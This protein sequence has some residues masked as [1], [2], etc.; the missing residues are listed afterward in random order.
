M[1][2]AF[3]A[4]LATAAP[5]SP[6]PSPTP[7]ASA[8]LILDRGRADR[9]PVASPVDDQAAPSGGRT[10]IEAA[11]GGTVIRRIVFA[12]GAVPARVAAAAQGFVGQRATAATLAEAAKAMAAAYARSDIALYS[13]VVPRQSF[14]GGVVR[15]VA[16][17]GFVERVV[18]K[19]G[20]T[21]LLRHYARA[22]AAERPLSRHTLERYISLMRD[23]AGGSVDVQILRGGRPGG[24]V[25]QIVSTRKRRQASLGFD[26]QGPSLLGDFETRGEVHAY[27]LLRDGDRTDLTGLAS[28]DFHRLL[29]V[30]G[31]HTT[32]IGATGGTASL[33]AGYIVTRPRRSVVD[34]HA[35]TFGLTTAWPILRGY[36]RNL[37][38]TLG[39]DGIDSDAAAFGTTISSDH[40]RALR[41]AAGYSYAG[42]KTA[43]S[44]GIT[45]SRGL[46]I[47]SARA[48]AGFTDTVFTKVNGRATY[49]AQIGKRL[50]VHLRAAGQY[51][52]DRL[53]GAERFAVGGADFGR[54]F[55]TAL[56]S[57]DRGA[58][59]SAE[60]AVRPN[61]PAR[62]AGSELYGFVDAATLRIV[63]RGSYAAG[64]FDLAS[65]GA[66]M[67]L[68]YTSRASV[69][70]E[71]ARSIDR[72]YPGYRGGWRVNF[73][74][75]LALARH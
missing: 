47:L 50:F 66:G 14:A 57:G 59:A 60:L 2:L 49:D 8:P 72:P 5:A 62:L 25:L 64:D 34:G 48:L 1:S 32:P 46:D 4:A 16:I 69:Q 17:E 24:V 30:A 43:L 19:S 9:A 27:S 7:G 61:L 54:A 71:A 68:A 13:V 52:R 73:G 15:I 20:E 33:S 51:S 65:A 35:T 40:T 58:A 22:L 70:L 39:L 45:V 42:A 21:P 23:V 67:R 28:P 3:A 41:G 37:S 44:A 10:A 11:A 36:K 38:L 55:D 31:A 26:N 18:F 29:Y 75:R 63:A 12:S 74:W 6:P 53:P 56:L